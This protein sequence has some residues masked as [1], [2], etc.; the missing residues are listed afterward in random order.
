MKSALVLFSLAMTLT[1]CNSSSIDVPE[2][3]DENPA[4]SITLGTDPREVLAQLPDVEFNGRFETTAR[5][6]LESGGTSDS[7]DGTL[8]TITPEAETDSLSV[9]SGSSD[10]ILFPGNPGQQIDPGTLTAGDYDDQLNPSLYQRYASNY[11]QQRGQWIDIPRMDFNQRIR[12][13]V[14][15]HSGSPYADANVV[16]SSADTQQTI[17]LRTAA[18]GVTALYNDI[19]SLPENFN[20]RVSGS[21]GTFVQQNINLQEATET[22]KI[23]VSLARGNQGQADTVAVPLDLMFVIDTTGSMSDELNFIQTELSDII[24]SVTRQQ[25][26]IRI[27]LVFYRDYGDQYVVRAHDFSASLNAVQ[28]DLNQ[29]QANGGGDFPEA[30]DQ[31]LQ[32][33]LSA[34]WRNSSRKVLFLVADAPPHSDRMRAT[35]N[36]AEQARLKNIHIVPVAASGAAE[37]AEYIMRSAAALTNSRYLFLTDDSGFGL[38]HDE[39]EID[40]YIV[41]SL[42]NTMIRTL[43]SLI[44]GTRTEPSANDIIRQVGDYNNGVCGSENSNS[45]TV[46]SS[47]LVERNNGGISEIR[48]IEVITDQNT[49][50][51]RLAAYGLVSVSVD[52]NEGQVILADAGPK[53]TGGY[54][55]DIGSIEEFDNHVVANI[56]FLQPGPTCGVTNA[57]THPF[58][59]VFV[60]TTKELRIAAN[61]VS[62]VCE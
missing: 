56:D 49:L 12:I 20:L 37:D 54:S 58:S 15:D 9:G 48:D 10:T 4:G 30:M 34:S 29:E 50:D 31:A 24:N 51:E 11:L 40:C 22:G 23:L 8:S 45:L 57:L 32:S 43:T 42:R 60:E 61:T 26:D 47:V 59:F 6:D 28:L 52:F 27:G 39:P 7:E 19:D 2:S 16:V 17:D 21:E 14:T 46:T 13:E 3:A 33:A 41:T 18:N 5:P 36:A 25:P 38:P 1:A 62:R 35:W 53:N 55:I 44:T